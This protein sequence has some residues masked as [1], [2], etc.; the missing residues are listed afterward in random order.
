MRESVITKTPY[1]L[2]LG[3]KERDN[4]TISYRVYGS[5]KTNTLP[6]DEFLE[7]IENEI[8]DMKRKE[9]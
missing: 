1:A 9:N 6:I 5:E 3:D 7:L 4:N 2:V 8:N